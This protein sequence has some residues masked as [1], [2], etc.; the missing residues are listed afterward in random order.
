[1]I[2]Q[3]HLKSAHLAASNEQNEGQTRALTQTVDKVIAEM[4]KVQQESQSG[5]VKSK[6][7]V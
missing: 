3:P 7:Y 2:V 1:M 5:K 6:H 4:T